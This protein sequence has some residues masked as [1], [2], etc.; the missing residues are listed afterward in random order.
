MDDIRLLAG[1]MKDDADIWLNEMK[2]LR[3]GENVVLD[4]LPDNNPKN[5]Y[6]QL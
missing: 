4:L 3:N 5:K 2:K 1:W 6:M